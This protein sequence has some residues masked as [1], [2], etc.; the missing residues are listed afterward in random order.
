MPVLCVELRAG[1]DAREWSR[2]EQELRHIA[3][4]Y[5]H[6]GKVAGFLRYPK[7]FPVDIRHNAKISRELLA[8]WAGKRL[9]PSLSPEAKGR[10]G[11]G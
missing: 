11:E 3:D 10:A 8:A 4:G 7:P 5:A 6:T 2:I 1:I 9:S